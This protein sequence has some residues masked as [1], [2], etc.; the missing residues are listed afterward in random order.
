MSLRFL[1]ELYFREVV[2]NGRR[3]RSS[4]VLG[5]RRNY[6]D[7]AIDSVE[8]CLFTVS[9]RSGF[10]HVLADRYANAVSARSP[11][12]VVRT[13]GVGFLFPV[14]KNVIGSDPPIG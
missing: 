6:G 5:V 3:K 7:A 11:L 12:Q 1:C 14:D 2:R 10:G 4:P 13:L 8:F 9:L